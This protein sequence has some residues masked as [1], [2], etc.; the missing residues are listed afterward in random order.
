MESFEYFPSVVYR[1]ENPE[2]AQ[3]LL[4]VCLQEL[5]RTRQPDCNVIQSGCL[6]YNKELVLENFK[7]YILRSARN[8]LV[9]Q[10]YSMDNWE[11]Y[12]SSLWAQEFKNNTSTNVH[13]HPNSQINGWLF[14]ETPA[15]GAFPVYL[16]SRYGK[17][18]VALDFVRAKKI[19]NAT[20]AVYFNNIVP[21]T[22][23]FNNSWFKHQLQGGPATNPTRCLHFIVS[24]K[25]R[26]C[27]IN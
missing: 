22:T 4:P 24:H 25:E 3:Q 12:I 16:D 20:D 5:A 1:E 18:L 11:L 13:S 27:N 2:L 21:G 7:S 9:E 15:E 19:T 8:I 17:E 14:L 26:A 23:L 6:R 10:G